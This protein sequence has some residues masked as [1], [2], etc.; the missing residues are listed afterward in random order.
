M[1]NTYLAED[2]DVDG[3]TATERVQ[4]LSK[5]R[6]MHSRQASLLLS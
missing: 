2:M 4:R 3:G 1:L 6:G 5:E